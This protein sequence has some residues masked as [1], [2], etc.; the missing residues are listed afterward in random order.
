MHRDQQRA[1]DQSIC[2]PPDAGSP[3]RRSFLGGLL[4]AG[5]AGVGALL[6]IPVIRFVL[7]PV[8]ATTTEKSWSEVG[9]VDELQSITVPVQKLV[10]IEQ[11]DGW[12]RTV[13]HVCT[14]LGCTVPWID[15][16]NKF[17]CPCH[18]AVFNPEGRLIGGPA[19]RSMDVLPTKVEQGVLKVQYQFFRQLTP[20]KEAVA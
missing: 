19:P 8:L 10:Q 5:T 13:S 3:P 4:A 17:V 14:H 20:K 7:H 11:L 16:Q 12:R 18:Q 6:I 2:S 1:N 9:K 15:K